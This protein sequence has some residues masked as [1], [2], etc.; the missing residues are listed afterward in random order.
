MPLLPVL[1]KGS[2]QNIAI[3]TNHGRYKSIS[4]LQ[5]SAIEQTEVIGVF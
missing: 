5:L 3:T 4:Q 1:H 2:A